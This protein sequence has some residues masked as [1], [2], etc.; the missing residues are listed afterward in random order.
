[1]NKYSHGKK[2]ITSFSSRKKSMKKRRTLKTAVAVIFTLIACSLLLTGCNTE[3]IKK[4]NTAVIFDLN[5]GTYR[6]CTLPVTHYYEIADGESSRIFDPYALTK[7][8]ITRAGYDLVGWFRGSKSESGEITF[9]DQWKFESDTVTNEGVTLYAKWKI[10]GTYTYTLCYKDEVTGEEVELGTYNVNP[11]DAFGDYREFV[12]KREGNY[13]ALPYFYDADGNLWDNQFRMPESEDGKKDVK[14]YA[15][16]VEGFYAMVT[17]KAS[18]ESAV[19]SNSHIYLLADIDF[20]GATFNGFNNVGGGLYTR[21]FIG[22]DHVIKNF[23]VIRSVVGQ[24]K[25]I[26]TRQSYTASLFNS[27]KGAYIEN[28]S[29]EGVNFVIDSGNKKNAII[30]ISPIAVKSENSTVKNVNFS[31]TYSIKADAAGVEGTDDFHVIRGN[32]A[33]YMTKGTASTVENVEVTVEKTEYK[34]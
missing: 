5:G 8:E 21:K 25:D 27:L 34:K 26:D 6:S 2:L 22:N 13:T 17:D 3:T 7:K 30:I 33:F 32:N 4:Q 9:G 28:V 20:G 11:G 14:V 24:D 19:R 23:K 18:L 1:M 12:K 10:H 15:K 31:G 16:Y 29:F